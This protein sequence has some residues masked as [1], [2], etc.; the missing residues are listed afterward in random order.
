MK[1]RRVLDDPT[2]MTVGTT[3]TSDANWLASVEHA[4]R[5]FN[6]TLASWCRDL[7]DARAQGLLSMGWV[8]PES[9]DEP[10]GAIARSRAA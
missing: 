10:T 6:S 7:L 8:A 3:S 1:W 9:S 5:V 2:G 4:R